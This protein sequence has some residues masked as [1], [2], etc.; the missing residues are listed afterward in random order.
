MSSGLD[1]VTSG[2]VFRKDHRMVLAMNRHQ[3]AIIGVRLAYEALGY[4]A[5]QLLARNSVSGLH[6]KYATSGS[7]GTD[8]AVG[9]LFN[10]VQD[11]AASTTDMGQMI[12]KGQLFESMVIGLD[13]PAKV[14]LGSRSVID[15]SGT[16][17]L[18]F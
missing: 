8:T 16:T 11:M 15:G 10:D 5:G 1:F 4:T 3:A 6:T 18:M 9:V 17:I 14:D 7:S 2:Q 13:A 12:V